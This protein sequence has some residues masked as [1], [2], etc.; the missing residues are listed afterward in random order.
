MRYGGTRLLF[1]APDLRIFRPEGYAKPSQITLQG[2]GM[3]DTPR[4]VIKPYTREV[5]R[6]LFFVKR[7]RFNG[8]DH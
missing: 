2:A 5:A 8:N 7:A 4:R 3:G 1:F 6:Y